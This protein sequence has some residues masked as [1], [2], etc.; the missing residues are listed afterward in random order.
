MADECPIDGCDKPR[1]ENQLMCKWHWYQVPKELRDKVWR[2]AK[3]MWR[4]EPD[5]T[6]GYQNWSEARDEAIHAVEAKED[7]RAEAKS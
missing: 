2:L 4:D 5:A 7:E 6:T 3:K 1:K